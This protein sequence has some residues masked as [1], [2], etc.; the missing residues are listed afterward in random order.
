MAEIKRNPIY[1]L[2]SKKGM[3]HELFFNVFE[4]VLASIVLLAILYFIHDVANQTI[5][6]KN[7]LARDLSALLNK[8]YAAPGDVAYDYN[9]NIAGFTFDFVGNK[10]DVHSKEGKDS[11]NV[12]YPF[13]KNDM[14]PFT[15]KTLNYEKG[16]FK[17]KFS[18]SPQFVSID[19]P[20]L[21]EK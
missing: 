3:T 6:E 9:E 4:L 7:Y 1:I 14:I 15:D 13:A 8:I 12:F 17:I 11:A 5:F 21:M 16:P 10:V 19:K 20:D 18:K 2:N